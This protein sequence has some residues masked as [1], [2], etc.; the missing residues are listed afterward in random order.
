MVYPDARRSFVGFQAQMK[1]SDSWPRKTE[2]L[3]DGISMLL[4][5]SIISALF[6]KINSNTHNLS[7][8]FTTFNAQVN[9]A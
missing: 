5:I 6:A 4:S 8:Y 3:L 7:F 1:T 2:T 9:Y